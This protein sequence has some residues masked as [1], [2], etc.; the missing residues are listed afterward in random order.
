MGSLGGGA[1]LLLRGKRGKRVLDRTHDTCYPKRL[2]VQ[3]PIVSRQT[4]WKLM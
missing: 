1:G 2:K 3:F 4:F